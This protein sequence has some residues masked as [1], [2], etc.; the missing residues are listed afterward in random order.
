MNATQEQIQAALKGDDFSQKVQITLESIAQMYSAFLD[1]DKSNQATQ[2]DF[3]SKRDEIKDFCE[4]A[5][6]ALS[7]IKTDI[8]ALG[9]AYSHNHSNAEA[10]GKLDVYN[11][12]HASKI[13][14]FDTHASE[15]I[16]EFDT[17]AQAKT[18]DFDTN[19]SKKTQAYNELVAST[20]ESMLEAVQAF[21]TQ[22]ESYKAQVQEATKDLESEMYISEDSIVTKLKIYIDK[23][24]KGEN[25]EGTQE[26]Q[27]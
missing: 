10:S 8:E 5:E 17:N 4:K 1:L 13:N 15:K 16:S 14:E 3:A 7:Q 20:K 19:A 9:A 26:G 18:Q 22:L 23:A 25:T 2:S 21:N 27:S 12:N 11:A 6:Q 24:I